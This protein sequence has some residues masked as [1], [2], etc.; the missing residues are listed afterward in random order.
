MACANVAGAILLASYHHRAVSFSQL[1]STDHD[2]SALGYKPCTAFCHAVPS[3]NLMLGNV[4]FLPEQKLLQYI[5]LWSP[6]FLGM[7]WR[8]T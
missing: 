3:P 8:I 6:D 5:L 4:V 7:S 1:I 2:L